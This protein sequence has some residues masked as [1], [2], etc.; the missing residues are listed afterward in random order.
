MSWSKEQQYIINHF[1]AE[2]KAIHW[3][4]KV[5]EPS[6]K[7]MTVDTIYEACDTYGRQ[8]YDVWGQ[9]SENIEKE[10]MRHLSESQIDLIFETISLTIG[11]EIYEALCDL[12][13]RL[14]EETGEDQSGLEEEILDFIKRD[15]AWACIEK[16]IQ[17]P[18]F[19]T[20]V[21]EIN[22]DGRWACSWIGKYPVGNFIIL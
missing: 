19:F 9:N 10:A 11:N 20:R 13:D 18:G 22:R 4:E 2:I 5:G 7:Y 14:G 1:V 21:Y 15:T 6:D 16:L 8:M 3:F 12:E 17:K